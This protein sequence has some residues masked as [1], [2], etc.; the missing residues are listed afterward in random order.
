MLVPDKL[1]WT[2]Y[3]IICIIITVIVVMIKIVAVFELRKSQM[4]PW[5]RTI[6]LPAPLYG[7]W[8]PFISEK[9]NTLSP[10]SQRRHSP[11]DYGVLRTRKY[12]HN[13]VQKL[14]TEKNGTTCNATCRKQT[15]PLFVAVF[16]HFLLYIAGSTFFSVRHKTCRHVFNYGLPHY[17]SEASATAP[18]LVKAERRKIK[19]NETSLT[20][21][22]WR[23]ARVNRKGHSACWHRQTVHPS[24]PSF[25]SDSVLILYLHAL[26]ASKRPVFATDA[27]EM[28]DEQRNQSEAQK[29]RTKLDCLSGRRMVSPS[30]P[31][32]I[33]P[34][35]IPSLLSP[36]QNTVTHLMSRKAPSV[37][38]HGP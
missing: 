12:W 22:R 2:K 14:E 33:S 19:I 5:W 27:A 20:P 6:Y 36:A 7:N 32:F 3:S 10:K 31:Q 17:Y 13:K 25:F 35:L 38:A 28:D 18:E 16:P 8:I 9:C 30:P 11:L 37:S 29:Q 23:H 4:S 24:E 1:F 21:H 34:S 26:I 15:E